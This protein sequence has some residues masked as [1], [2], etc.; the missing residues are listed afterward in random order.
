MNY[1]NLIL[2]TTLILLCISC[3]NPELIEL[4]AAIDEF[5]Y[6]QNNSDVEHQEIERLKAKFEQLNHSNNQ[7][8]PTVLYYLSNLALKQNKLQEAYDFISMAYNIDR[9]DSIYIQKETIYNLLNPSQDTMKILEND[10]SSNTVQS[11]TSIGRAEIQ[12]LY[13]KQKYDEAINQTKSLIAMIMSIEKLE[14]I[15]IELSQLY[16][17]LAIFYAKQHNMTEA[18][19][20]INKAIDIN[21]TG[22]NEE[23]KNLINKKE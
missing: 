10:N 17:D 21:P 7:L 22:V 20:M 11:I 1:K 6:L 14:N 5:E 15:K 3:K 18:K 16:Q 12:K 8:Q 4:E 23:I 13:Q 2:L 9:A 19:N